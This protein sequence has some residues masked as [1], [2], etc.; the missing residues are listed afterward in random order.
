MA[1]FPLVIV[2]ERIIQDFLEPS[3][4]KVYMVDSNIFC[5]RILFFY[6]RRFSNV[7]KDFGNS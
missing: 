6:E 5:S 1:Y 2:I 3:H 7:E 4:N